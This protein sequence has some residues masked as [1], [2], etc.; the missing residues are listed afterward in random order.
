M[1]G[2][3]ASKVEGLIERYCGRIQPGFAR[4]IH[5]VFSAGEWGLAAAELAGALIYD[6][7]AVVPDDKAFL[8]ELL[9]KIELPPDTP[10]DIADQLPVD[11]S[12][13]L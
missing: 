2:Q 7:I 8:L 5:S 10:E 3:Y 9:R 12:S 6:G 13:G 1:E 11:E 4:G